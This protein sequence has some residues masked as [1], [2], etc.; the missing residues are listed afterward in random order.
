MHKFILSALFVVGFSLSGTAQDSTLFQRQYYGDTKPFKHVD[1]SISAGTTG[2]GI[3]ASTKLSDLFRLRVGASFMPH[4]KQDMHFG[5]RVGDQPAVQYDDQGNRIETKFDR[6]QT[7][8]KQLTGYDV[9]D[10]ITM[11]GRP[12][13]WNA[14]LIVDVM[15]FK[16]KHWHISAGFYL[17]NS[18]LAD[19]EVSKGDMTTMLAVGMYDNMYLKAMNNEP[20]I[21]YNDQ[22]IYNDAISDRLKNYGRMQYYIGKIKGTDE[23]CYVDPDANGLIRVEAKVNK[24]K[25]YI[26]FGYEG[27]LSKKEPQWK[28][29]FDAGVLFYGGKPKV[30]TDRTVEHQDEDPTTGI[31]T[32]S[33][34]KERIDMARDLYDYPSNIKGKMD[35]LKSMVVFPVLNVKII[36]TF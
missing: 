30:Y 33:Y 29:G 17:G 31:I 9:D 10:N 25:P 27:L 35:L 2:L 28:F 15:P 36:R 5:V 16:N 4:W 6:L 34:T 23:N 18:L 14:S 32:Y 12:K 24:F 11:E 19:A 3:E 7:R 8:M 1:V 26:G 22:M 13:Y 21:T 20:F